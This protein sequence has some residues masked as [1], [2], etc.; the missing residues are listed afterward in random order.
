M[1][2]GVGIFRLRYPVPSETFIREQ[3]A[4]LA[5]YQPTIITRT[6]L[7]DDGPAPDNAIVVGGGA[8]SAASR[9]A[10]AAYVATGAPTLFGPRRTWPRLALLHAHFGP[11]ATYA[12]PLAE[13]LDVP[14]VTSFHGWDVTLP[15]RSY[16]GRASLTTW[17]YVAC[18]AALRRQG[19]AFIAASNYIRDRLVALGYPRDRVVRLYVGVDLDRFQP[20][21]QPVTERFV[22]SVARHTPQ[23]GLD[24]LI[25]AFA[26]IAAR[27]PDLELVQVGAG[28]LTSKL[29]E[30]AA[31][32]GLV[33]RVRF[34]GMLSHDA[35]RPLMARAAVVALTSQ[36]PPTGQQEALGLVLNEAGASG[37]PV[38]ATRHGGMP[39]AVIDGETGLLVPERDDRAVAEALETIVSDRSLAARMGA[40]GR[41]FVGDVFNLRT[42]TAA[43]EDLYDRVTAAHAPG[44]RSRDRRDEGR[45]RVS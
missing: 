16:L 7:P 6:W 21:R 27:F 4:A 35:V 31:R 43:L 13:S 44:A 20:I 23:K 28:P 25:R 45:R 29:Q 34:V 14:L 26:R 9:A 42:Q 17:R 5:R 37:V 24:T 22:L 38:V 41:A 19:A 36:T 3:T 15:L 18:G 32:H 11:D 30:L 39:E 33:D 1:V 2:S 8:R 12:L 40:R 10:R